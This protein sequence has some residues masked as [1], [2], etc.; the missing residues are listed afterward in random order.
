MFGEYW[1]YGGFLE[2][3]RKWKVAVRQFVKL[4]GASVGRSVQGERQEWLVW[5]VAMPKPGAQPSVL[6]RQVRGALKKLPTD[7]MIRHDAPSVY[8]SGTDVRWYADVRASYEA[9]WLFVPTLNGTLADAS[10][11]APCGGFGEA[12]CMEMAP[13][14]EMKGYAYTLAQRPVF[15]TVWTLRAFHEE[16][17][18]PAPALKAWDVMLGF[19]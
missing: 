10:F 6:L 2:Y 8:R 3:M 7:C 4:M 12:D 5:G 17:H 1:T 15:A 13:L 16:M 14:C 9:T 11:E 18:K 19:A